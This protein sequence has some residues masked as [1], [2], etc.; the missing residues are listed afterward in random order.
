MSEKIKIK[1]VKILSDDWYTYKQVTCEIDIA[2]GNWKVQ[3]REV[4]DRGDGA[5]ILL[6]NSIKK[7]VILTR[8]F[9]LPTYLNGH[10]TGQLIET[11]AGSVEK[12]ESPEENIKRETLEETGYSILSPQ[13]VFEAYMS[14]GAVTEKIHF[15]VAPYDDSLKVESG[16]GHP[17]ENEYIEVME[18]L[19]DQALGMMKRGEIQDAKTIM[20]LQ[21]ALLN[22]LL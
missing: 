16:G 19:F 11:C 20:L 12:N 17:D 21:Y 2:N 3:K 9:R 14:P 5:T 1:D 18:L 13:K 22:Q 7:T 6:Y 4:L 8:Q 15:F 10:P